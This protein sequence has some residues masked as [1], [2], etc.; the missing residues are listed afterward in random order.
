MMMLQ[1]VSIVLL[2]STTLGIQLYYFYLRFITN[3]SSSQDSLH[4]LRGKDGKLLKLDKNPYENTSSWKTFVTIFNSREPSMTRI[5]NHLERLL[6]LTVSLA[7]VFPVLAGTVYP[8]SSPPGH[9][10]R[11]YSTVTGILGIMEA[12]QSHY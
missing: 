4:P 7:T 2:S 11:N 12:Y 5:L 9:L 10:S 1:V 6:W 3:I 8:R